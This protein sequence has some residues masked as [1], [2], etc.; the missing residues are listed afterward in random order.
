[1]ETFI[2]ALLST[3]LAQQSPVPDAESQRKAEKVV[4]EVFGT[5][6]LKKPAADRILF[7]KKLIQQGIDTKDDP[8]SQ[9]VMFREARDTAARAGDLG[10]AFQAIE[11]IGRRFQIDVPASKVAILATIPQEARPEALKPAAEACLKLADEAA[12][13]GDFDTAEKAAAAAV[14]A[15]RKTKDVPLVGRAEARSR[16]LADLK[17][18]AA[19][20]KKARET[21]A[22]APDDPAANLEVGLFEGFV[23]GAWDAGLPLLAKGSDEALR[24]PGRQ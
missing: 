8:V 6:H 15:A 16:D 18:R 21:L 11:E 2:A 3:C 10:V 14:A 20:A 1:M 17:G 7:A 19:R 13:A 12:A 5:D 23:K 24:T 4:H 22:A 9:Y